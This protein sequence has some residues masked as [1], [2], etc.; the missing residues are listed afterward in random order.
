MRSKH[1]QKLLNQSIDQSA[2]SDKDKKKFKK[3]LNDEIIVGNY[4]L[5]GKNKSYLK[6]VQT[7]LAST[8]WNGW[9]DG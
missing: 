2:L 9:D 7:T 4:G 6:L 5:Y 1:H 8:L 3:V